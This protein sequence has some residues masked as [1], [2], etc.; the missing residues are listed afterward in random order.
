M[1]QK[2]QSLF[3]NVPRND[4]IFEVSTSVAPMRQVTMRLSLTNGS[5]NDY[6]ISKAVLLSDGLTNGAPFEISGPS[7][8]P[9]LSTS[10]NAR[11]PD[12]FFL[13]SREVEVNSIHLSRFCMFHGASPGEYQVSFYTYFSLYTANN[14][15]LYYDNQGGNDKVE[16]SYLIGNSSFFIEELKDI[17]RISGSDRELVLGNAPE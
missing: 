15:Y 12:L 2:L 10:H 6:Y 4:I 9:C 17:V 5:P 14:S 3:T 13:K 16:F 11:K 1:G 7:D 8:I